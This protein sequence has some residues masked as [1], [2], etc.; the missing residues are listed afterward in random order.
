MD[1]TRVVLLAAGKGTRLR[2]LTE[3]IPKCL[4]KVKGVPMLERWI[5]IVKKEDLNEIL[6][7]THYLAEKVNEYIS[8]NHGQDKKI[9]LSHEDRLLGTA[10]TIYKH[11]DWLKGYQSIIVHADNYYEGG[12]DY[13]LKAHANRPSQCIMTMLTFRCDDAKSCGMVKVDAQN[14]V[15]EYKE[16]DKNASGNLANAAIYVISNEF[17]EWMEENG[18]GLEEISKEIIPSLI[19]KIYT[20]E[21]RAKLVDIGTPE[22]LKEVEYD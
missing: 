17:I 13:I 2:P 6:I 7:N 14:I 21:S 22:R 5:K 3:K 9:K 15:R 8:K 19:G 16:K 20:V 12:I 18:Q 4:V 11:L 10:G 1:K